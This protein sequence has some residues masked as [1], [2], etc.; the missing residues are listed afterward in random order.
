MTEKAP[1]IP[2]SGE[3]RSK[4]SKIQIKEIKKFFIASSPHPHSIVAAST[5]CRSILRSNM[6]FHVKFFDDIISLDQLNQ[7]AKTMQDTLVIPVGLD[8]IG[9]TSGSEKRILGI[10]SRFHSKLKGVHEHPTES[11]IGAEVLAFMAETLDVQSE[12]L[13]LAAI[14]ALLEG[15]KDS[16]TNAIVDAVAKEGIL[17]SRK[18]FRIPGYNF[19]PMNE[20]F[21]SNIHPYLD[22]LS[23]SPESCQKIFHDADITYSKWTTPLSELTS[24]EA[25]QLNAILLLSLTSTE[26]PEVLGT[27]Y[28]CRNE[29]KSSPLRYFSSISSLSRIAWSKHAMGLLLGVFIGD[30]ARL[31]GNLTEM[32]R[33]YCNETISSVA[34]LNILL[35][36]SDTTAKFHESYIQV[37]GS[38]I[39]EDILPDVGRI[40][41]ASPIAEDAKFIVIDSDSSIAITWRKP[42]P[43]ISVS[44]ALYQ[45]KIPYISTSQQ[46]V[47][48][49]KR[50]EGDRE[51]IIGIIKPILKDT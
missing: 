39:H 42:T 35:N 18:G 36:E 21:S 22:T 44:V 2:V 15:K 51:K 33:T 45:K 12:E 14:S 26:I 8:V 7:Y 20:V 3:L 4:F 30:R 13:L 23:G 47:K 27:D 37:D 34:K 10:G 28:E 38:N 48:I 6:V 29:K 32:Y 24:S 46:S 1:K 40:T 25:R 5:L 19:L 49:T 16:I 50:S 11:P 43:L 9:A 17:I 31:L 41:L